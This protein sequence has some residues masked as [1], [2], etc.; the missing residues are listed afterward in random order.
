M[1]QL[2]LFKTLM[3]PNTYYSYSAILIE[4]INFYQFS[5]TFLLKEIKIIVL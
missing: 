3:L 1:A 4:S 5:V 2:K